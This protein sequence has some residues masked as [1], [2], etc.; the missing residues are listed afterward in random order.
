MIIEIETNFTTNFA[1]KLCQNALEHA[2]MGNLGIFKSAR[3]CIFPMDLSCCIM[4][5]TGNRIPFTL[6][7]SNYNVFI[8]PYIIAQS[9]LQTP[10]R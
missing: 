5:L 7:D 4:Y 8:V 1:N 2:A 3:H 10:L 9:A 6:T